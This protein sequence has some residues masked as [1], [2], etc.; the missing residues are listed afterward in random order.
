MQYTPELYETIGLAI[1]EFKRYNRGKIVTHVELHGELWDYFCLPNSPMMTAY[2]INVQGFQINMFRGLWVSEKITINSA[3]DYY[4]GESR[5]CRHTFVS[6]N[7]FREVYKFC[8][9][10]DLKIFPH[11]NQEPNE[12]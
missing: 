9:K 4:L 11:Y 10:C 3:Y 1:E 2:P 8:T 5:I 12:A 7:G 6:Y